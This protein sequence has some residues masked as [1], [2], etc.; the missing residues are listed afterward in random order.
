[1]Q[2]LSKA[3]VTAQQPK[4]FYEF[5]NFRID[6]EERVL[7]RD[8]KPLPLTP[9]VFDMLLALVQRRCQ[10][11]S[12]DELMRLVWPDTFVE[13]GNLTQNIWVL[14]KLLGESPDEP[15]FIKT[16][17]RRGYRF[18]APVREL[19]E[20]AAG[21]ELTSHSPLPVISA[22]PEA[23]GAMGSSGEAERVTQ[24]ARKGS[25]RWVKLGSGLTVSIAILIMAGLVVAISS[26]HLTHRP[27]APSPAI[28]S[29]A[30]LPFMPLSARGSDESFGLEMANAL[31]IELSSVRQIF[32]RPTTAVRRYADQEIDPVR[33]GQEQEVDAVL[34]A[35]YQRLGERIRVTAQLLD[36]RD[37]SPL[38]AEKFDAQ[39]TDSFA[40][41]DTISAR[42][43]G[44]LQLRLASAEREL[45]SK[46]STENQLANPA[47]KSAGYSQ[48]SAK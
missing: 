12:K 37:G 47:D 17:P 31:I 44:A 13:E 43:A 22:E 32:V 27:T 7:F 15:Q 25:G 42:V 8:G 36:V 14:R 11:V 3:S 33:A 38:W 39:F 10:V 4:P 34:V 20:Q 45:L 18:V 9:K 21:G 23:P 28:K 41:Q 2:E 5:S 24:A 19:Q 16:V 29:I 40:A 30:V 46:S 1:M 35:S 48:Y 6:P 26:W